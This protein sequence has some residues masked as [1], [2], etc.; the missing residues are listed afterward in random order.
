MNSPNVYLIL[1]FMFLYIILHEIYMINIDPITFFLNFLYIKDADHSSPKLSLI[2]IFL[3]TYSVTGLNVW[4]SVCSVGIV[5]TFYTTI[6]STV[7]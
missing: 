5:C 7:K 1:D 2:T 3:F 4:I 6:V